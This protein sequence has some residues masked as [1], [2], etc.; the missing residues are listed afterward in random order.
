MKLA[1]YQDGSRDGQLVVVSRDLSQAHYASGIA[2]RLQ[3]VLDDWNFLAPQLAELYADLN[4]GRAPHAFAFEPARCLAP[5][6]RASQHAIGQAWPGAGQA[7]RRGAAS[8]PPMYQGAGDALLGACAPV[9]LPAEGLDIDFEAGLAAIT[10]DIPAGATP[11]AALHGVRLLA[12]VSVVALRQ[13]EAAERAAGLGLLRARPATAFSPVAVTPDE[14]E[15]AWQDGRIHLTLQ[16]SCNGRRVGMCEAGS[17]M[18]WHLGELIAHLATT[19]SVRAGTIVAAA[20]VANR[21]A[22]RGWASI[23][24]R[25]RIE[26]AEA[27]APATG[28]LRFGDSVRVEM[29]SRLG[30]SVFGAIEQTFAPL[31]DAGEAF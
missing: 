5:L 3:Q 2:S 26:Q 11:E 20:P 22:A 14:L 27:G 16:C 19:R 12:L 24:E 18:A 29:K 8:P 23:A 13:L 9:R 17:D 30:H 1:T 4:Q 31:H 10:A 7:P 15:G 21:D 6:P 28:W 25:R